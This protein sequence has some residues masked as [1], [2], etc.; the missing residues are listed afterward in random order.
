MEIGGLVGEEEID[1]RR[2]DHVEER[3]EMIKGLKK[4]YGD[5]IAAILAYK[6]RA[7]EDLERLTNSEEWAKK[8]EGELANLRADLIVACE[9]LSAARYAAAKEYSDAALLHVRDLGMANARF[10]IEVEP[11]E[12]G[13]EE[14]RLTAEGFDMVRFLFSANP[15]EPVKPL[16]R[17]ASG[18]EMSRVMLA[19]KSVTA[20]EIGCLI[21]DEI[22]TGVSGRMAQ[23]VGEKIAR[24]AKGRQVI[25]VTHLPQIA[26]M[27][28]EQYV[29]YKTEQD[30][31]A[32]TRV[33]RLDGQ[34]RVAEIARLV[35]GADGE[36]AAR[37]HAASM[38][39]AA[40]ARKKKL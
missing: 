22:D 14:D 37:E 34:G 9:A 23:A 18:G 25:C 15:G 33:E 40:A 32:G 30:G 10:V 19:L 26:C 39:K 2:I 20:G 13:F 7:E 3:L 1:P 36:E 29:V 6:E 17:I 28:D 24:I 38:L 11:P 35:G 12:E 5:D 4:K 27:A 8:L 31:R 16:A 21:F